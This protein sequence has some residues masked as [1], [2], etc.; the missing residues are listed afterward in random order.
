MQSGI[1]SIH[2]NLFG[3]EV[4]CLRGVQLN[5]LQQTWELEA[6]FLGVYLQSFQHV[7]HYLNRQRIQVW[8]LTFC[9]KTHKRIK[10][11]H[12]VMG[13][14]WHKLYSLYY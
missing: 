3:H 7:L 9:N 1:R 6:S 4:Q 10:F 5:D 8:E 2:S 13:A 12:W 11:D 14:R